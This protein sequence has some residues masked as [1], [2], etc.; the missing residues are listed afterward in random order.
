MIIKVTREQSLQ[1]RHAFATP[2]GQGGHVRTY[3]GTNRFELKA[4]GL[5][6]P[7]A[8]PMANVVEQEA[9]SVVDPHFHGVDQ[10]QVFIGG[11]GRVGVHPIEPIT[12]HFAGPHSPYGPIF[13]GPEGADYLTLRPSWDPGAQWMPESAP[14]LRA[15]PDRK[16]VA[17]VS[18]RI[19]TS[20]DTAFCEGASATEVMPPAKF[21]G[22]GVWSWRAGPAAMLPAGST[23]PQGQ[24]WYVL[25]GEL[26]VEGESLG[27]GA[28]VFLDRHESEAVFQAGPGGVQALQLQFPFR[29]T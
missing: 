16:Q 19:D 14:H 1:R 21:N 17:F 2:K 8:G 27:A 6:R 23:G 4:L 9:A 22:A 15:I 10:F 12:V 13:A 5:D 20:C 26:V 29:E 28:C 25:S 3:M 11:G 18:G 7:P 24:F